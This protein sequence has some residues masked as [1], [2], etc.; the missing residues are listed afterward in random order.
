MTDLAGASV[1]TSSAGS[2]TNAM[3]NASS[4]GPFGGGWSVRAAIVSTLGL[5]APTYVAEA[6]RQT[7]LSLISFESWRLEPTNRSRP[8]TTTPAYVVSCRSVLGK[9]TRK[10]TG[11]YSVEWTAQVGVYVYGRS[12]DETEDLAWIYI[13]ALRNA[14]LQH[15]SLGGIAASTWWLS[16]SYRE[17]EPQSLR[18]EG[19]ALLSVG[20]RVDD[21][22]G[23]YSGPATPPANVNEPAPGAPDVVATH[24]ALDN[25]GA[26]GVLPGQP[27]PSVNP[28]GLAPT[29]EVAGV[30]NTELAD[31]Q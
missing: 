9:P 6:S 12:W 14:L 27:L 15:P 7:G 5:W 1:S 30:V 10:G 24:I 31:E 28:D 22:L 11:F 20:V 25:V 4:F 23:A 16:E 2:G 17:I 19:M 29:S 21:V 3:A 8:A 13:A 18:T 26:N